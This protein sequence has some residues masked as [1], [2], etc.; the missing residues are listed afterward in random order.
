VPLDPPCWSGPSS[1]S[2]NRAKIDH[3]I[4]T[5]AEERIAS[6][7]AAWHGQKLVVH[8]RRDGNMTVAKEAKALLDELGA[9]RKR[10]VK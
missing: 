1:P 8:T 5:I 2:S 3:G 4:A 7:I 9:K 6:L 10:A